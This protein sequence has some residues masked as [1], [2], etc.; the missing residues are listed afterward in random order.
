MVPERSVQQLLMCFRKTDAIIADFSKAFDKVNHKLLLTKLDLM[1]VSY[2]SLRWLKSYLTGRKQIVCVNNSLSKYIYVLSGVYQG[3][4]L[5]PLQFSL[6]MNDLPNMINYANILMYAD[7][8]KVFLSFNN[9]IEHI[10][11]QSDLNNFFLWCECNMM[12]LNIKECKCSCSRV[13]I[14]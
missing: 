9:V 12:E 13:V 8:V 6:F 4:H 7:D 5:D 14:L 10:Y 2:K 1:C 3:S 11:L